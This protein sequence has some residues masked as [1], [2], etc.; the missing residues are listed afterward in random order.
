MLIR[1]ALNYVGLEDI[2]LKKEVQMLNTRKVNVRKIENNNV[3]W[4][5]LKTFIQAPLCG[6]NRIYLWIDMHIHIHICRQWQLMKKRGH[7]FE[8]DQRAI[9][10]N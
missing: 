5:A 7:E 2:V 9:G 6:M 10:D 4:S 8:G 3:K 1:G